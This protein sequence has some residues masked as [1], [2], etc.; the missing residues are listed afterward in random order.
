MR[1]LIAICAIVD[2][3]GIE[4][5]LHCSGH[6]GDIGHKGITVFIGELVEVI[7]MILVCHETTSVISLLLKQEST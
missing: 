3:L 4:S 6:L 5:L 7:D 1:Q 2:L